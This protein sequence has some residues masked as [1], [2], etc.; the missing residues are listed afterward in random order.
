MT[1]RPAMMPTYAAEALERMA[2]TSARSE[3]F[4]EHQQKMMDMVVKHGFFMF[5]GRRVLLTFEDTGQPTH[6]DKG[7]EPWRH[8]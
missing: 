6:L 5:C 2:A 1:D 8:R 7:L 4:R 3:E